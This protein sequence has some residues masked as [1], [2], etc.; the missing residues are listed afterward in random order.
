MDF[1]WQS[2]GVVLL[3]TFCGFQEAGRL[4]GNSQV[5]G[6]WAP[7]DPESSILQTA[8]GDKIQDP[9][10]RIQDT[11]YSIHIQKYTGVEGYEDASLQGDLG[12]RRQDRLNPSKPGGPSKE[13]PGDHCSEG[14]PIL[15]ILP[16][17]AIGRVRVGF[18]HGCCECPASRSSESR[19]WFG[20]GSCPQQGSRGAPKK[21][22]F[23]TFPTDL[24]RSILFLPGCSGPLCREIL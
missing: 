21:V 18:S 5:E 19:I 20:H 6:T 22:V 9:R 1:S 24:F 16:M 23:A 12:C 15:D 14:C 11:A 3:V 8:T 4:P 2:G 10:H 13:G 17:G 7:W